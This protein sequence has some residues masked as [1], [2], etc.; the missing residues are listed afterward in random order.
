VRDNLRRHAQGY[1]RKREQQLSS[2]EPPAGAKKRRTEA[3]TACPCRREKRLHHG[4]A[5]SLP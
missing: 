5:G 4:K 1:R 2:E 3:D